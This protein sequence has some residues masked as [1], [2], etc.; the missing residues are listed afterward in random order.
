VQ[1]GELTGEVKR[2]GMRSSTVR[3]WQGAEV[4]VPNGN[5][6]SQEVINW[7][8]S[9]RQRRI[10]VNVGVAYGTDSGQVMHLLKEVAAE[11]K[12]VLD[13]PP[14]MVLFLGFGDSALLFELRSWTG[15]DKFLR[16]RSDVT[17]AV[18]QAL[19]KAGI[20]IPFPQRDLHVKSIA[21]DAQDAFLSSKV[22]QERPADNDSPPS[23]ETA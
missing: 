8:L 11:N 4:I 6:I 15:Q 1:I 13:T 5:L 21:S 12:D 3:T 23:P 2:I 17:V 10:D 9:D 18:E 19:R 22:P 20:T 14:P 16:V 7:T